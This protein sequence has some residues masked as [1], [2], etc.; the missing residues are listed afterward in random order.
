MKVLNRHAQLKKK[1]LRVSHSYIYIKHLYKTRKAIMKRFYLQKKVF[2]KKN[3]S[4]F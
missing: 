4:V 1:V 3:R 2:K